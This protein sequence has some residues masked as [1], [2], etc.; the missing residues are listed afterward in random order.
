LACAAVAIIRTIHV[1]L[2]FI[3]YGTAQATTR[4]LD[5]IL[6]HDASP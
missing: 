2:R 3:A 5:R 1:C 6:P 4:N